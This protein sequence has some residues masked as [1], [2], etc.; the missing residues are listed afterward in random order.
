MQWFR[1][2]YGSLSLGSLLGARAIG[3]TPVL[4]SAWGRD[5]TNHATGQ[6]VVD[7][8][9]SELHGGGTILLHDS[10]CTS[11]PGSWRSALDAI[12]LLADE[13]A[14]RSLSVATL[15]NHLTVRSR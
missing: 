4:W 3:V 6:T 11:A 9:R 15:G 8:L 1:P 5:W 10:D 2:P 14:S 13:L 12:D 7:H